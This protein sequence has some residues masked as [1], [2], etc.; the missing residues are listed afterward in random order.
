M[1]GRSMRLAGAPILA[2]LVACGSPA[3]TPDEATIADAFLDAVNAG[4]TEA[5]LALMAD[6]VV[7]QSHGVLADD[8]ARRAYL[9]VIT[10]CEVQKARAAQDRPGI[11]P[12]VQP[13]FIHR[14]GEA[15]PG[16]PDSGVI[17]WAVHVEDSRITA[18]P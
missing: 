17:E 14:D 5:A 4:D 18:V 8:A 9:V 1:F 12:I 15:C 6:D 11:D 13:L 2:L 10:T 7:S 16:Y 3:A